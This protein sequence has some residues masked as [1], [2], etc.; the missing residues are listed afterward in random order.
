M[1]LFLCTGSAR[2]HSYSLCAR[3]PVQHKLN[4]TPEEADQFRRSRLPAPTTTHASLRQCPAALSQLQPQPEL[5]TPPTAWLI[6]QDR[7]CMQ[8]SCM[9]ACK[10]TKNKKQTDRTSRQTQ[11]GIGHSAPAH[12][13]G[14]MQNRIS[15]RQVR[16]GKI[17]HSAEA[18]QPRTDGGPSRQ[19]EA[20]Q[21]RRRRGL[22]GA[23][24]R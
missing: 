11:A 5:Q 14:H 15:R 18:E 1:G 19:A 7:G 13:G 3:A 8:G 20:C 24:H 21:H 17:E 9:G 16:R 4:A 6:V 10:K 2:Q 23:H 22:A 12:R